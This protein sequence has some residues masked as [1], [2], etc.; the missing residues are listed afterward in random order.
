MLPKLETPNVLPMP[1]FPLLP[2]FGVACAA[3]T[4]DPNGDDDEPNAGGA[5]LFVIV[6][7]IGFT[8]ALN[9]GVAAGVP[10]LPSGCPKLGAVDW[11]KTGAGSTIPAERNIN[12]EVAGSVD[13]DDV[14]A[15][16]TGGNTGV[17]G[18]CCGCAGG[19]CCCGVPNVDAIG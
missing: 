7:P 9:A 18:N 6:V 3:F 10:K 5:V 13:K 11:P 8:L 4:V 2:K 1:L 14:M 12:G 19:G 15:A 17:A 16:A